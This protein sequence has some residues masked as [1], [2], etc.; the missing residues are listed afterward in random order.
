MFFSQSDLPLSD[1]C[2]SLNVLALPLPFTAYTVQLHGKIDENRRKDHSHYPGWMCV[3]SAS[4]NV[5]T[6]D[7]LSQT[8]SIIVM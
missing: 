5:F 2:E 1:H 6:D 8:N 7:I 4:V 3:P